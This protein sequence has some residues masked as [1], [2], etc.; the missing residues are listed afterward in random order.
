MSN[1]YLF[2]LHIWF[3][4]NIVVVVAVF[5]LV[6]LVIEH[7]KKRHAIRISCIEN[8][9]CQSIRTVCVCVCLTR[10]NHG[11]VSSVHSSSVNGFCFLFV[12]YSFYLDI[13]VILYVA[14]AVAP[15][16]RKIVISISRSLLRLL[17]D[18]A[19]LI[20]S[21]LNMK[22]L[23][24]F[25]FGLAMKCFCRIISNG[26]G[27]CIAPATHTHTHKRQSRCIDIM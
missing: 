12:F 7:T 5:V 6:R 2:H 14:L 18:V 26:N 22:M 8:D 23:C 3:G 25:S 19:E 20:L 27:K 9:E 15:Q 11:I 16:V 4:V 17:V 13:V 1:F 10:E 24:V 21:S